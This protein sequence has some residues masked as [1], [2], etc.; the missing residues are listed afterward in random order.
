MSTLDHIFHALSDPN[1]RAVIARLASGD[2]T[3]SELQEPLSISQPSISRHLKVL[4]DA[5]IIST[6]IEGSARPR[7]ID[8]AAFVE[9]SEWLDQ[10]RA[11]WARNFERLDTYLEEVKRS[12]EHED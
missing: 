1:R 8:P 2:A 7:R 10:Y 6:R 12:G 3:V 5:G 9:I 11:V 4:E